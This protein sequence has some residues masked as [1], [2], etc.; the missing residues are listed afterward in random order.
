MLFFALL[1][2]LSSQSLSG[3]LPLHTKIQYSGRMLQTS[4]SFASTTPFNTRLRLC[5]TH[6]R[7]Q[8]FAHSIPTIRSSWVIQC[9]FLTPQTTT[10]ITTSSKAK[11]MFI[12]CGRPSSSTARAMPYSSWMAVST[13]FT[14]TYIRLPPSR[15]HESK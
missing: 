3:A 12:G 1:F 9:R 6:L 15:G 8:S 13:S 11:P 4:T 7:P 2:F 5:T 10:L 14:R